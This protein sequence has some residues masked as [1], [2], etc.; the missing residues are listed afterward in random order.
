M[1]YKFFKCLFDIIFS[2]IGLLM[3]SPIFVVIAIII[4]KNSKGTIFYRGIRSGKFGKPFKIF[5][6]RTMIEDAEKKGGPSTALNDPR[7]TKIG[8]FLRKYKLDE[9]P[10]L[11]NIL[12][13]KMS[14]V[15][16]R[17]Q[18]EKYTK[19]Y[20]DEEKIILSV[21]PGLTDYASIEFVNLD[22]ILG[23]E[24]ID[25]KYLKEIEPK[26]NQLRIKYVKNQSLWIDFKILFKTFF[27]LFK[28]KSL[29]N[30]KD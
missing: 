28:I 18:V 30:T 4:K 12:T 15:G 16:P 29:W 27:L 7:L 24:N 25:D 13:G 3:L 6:F 2:F 17:P 23:D 10:Q 26:K 21:K 19:L 20:N 5:K 9:L 11:I 8:K 1:I 22:K 14:F